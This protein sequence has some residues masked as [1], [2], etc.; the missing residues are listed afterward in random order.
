MIIEKFKLSLFLFLAFILLTNAGLILADETDMSVFIV[1]LLPPSGLS[2]TVISY[3]Q[4]NLSWS[5]VAEAESYN[6]YKSGALIASVNTNSYSVT[7]LEASTSYSFTVSSVSGSGESSQSS[8]VSAITSARE[9]Q[10][11]IIGGSYDPGS[12][13]DNLIIPAQKKDLTAPLGGFKVTINEGEIETGDSA[14]LIQLDGGLDAVRVE[15]SNNYDFKNSVTE[16]YVEKKSW[17]LSVGDGLKNVYVRFLNNDDNFSPVVSDSIIL[18]SISPQISITKIKNFY[19]VNEEVIIEGTINES[20]EVIFYWDKKYGLMKVTGNQKWVVNLG[21]MSVGSHSVILMAKDNVNNFK[22]ITADILIK[23]QAIV[24]AE[25]PT[26]LFS[27]IPFV[28]ENIEEKIKSIAR[29]VSSEQEVPLRIV[30]V[31]QDTPRFLDGQWN[32]LPVEPLK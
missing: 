19:E 13:F 26:K 31:S 7:G 16:K 30:I 18:D 25:K 3:Q 27:F 2:A 1:P 21:K 28:F 24:P 6:V 11:V 29:L 22:T 9:Q 17:V 14:V 12:I 23:A 5:T 8:A 32:L 15:I 20:A 4:I 10:T